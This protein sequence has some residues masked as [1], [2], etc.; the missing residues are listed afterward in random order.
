MLACSLKKKLKTMPQSLALKSSIFL[1]YYFLV[2]QSLGF[3]PHILFCHA[4]FINDKLRIKNAQCFMNIKLVYMLKIYN[5]FQVK[6]Y[7]FYANLSHTKVFKVSLTTNTTRKSE[8]NNLLTLIKQGNI[9][10]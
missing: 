5:L 4:F 1:N 6:A 9:Y 7:P 8:G 10:D 2:L 3:L